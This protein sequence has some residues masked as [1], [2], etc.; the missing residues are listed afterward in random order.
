M[1]DVGNTAD[2]EH[3]IESIEI[4][5]S[6]GQTRVIPVSKDKLTQQKVQ[7][8][9]TFRDKSKPFTFEAKSAREAEKVRRA[10][11]TFSP[12]LPSVILIDNN[13]IKIGNGEVVDCTKYLYRDLEKRVSFTHYPYPCRN[14][15]KY[16]KSTY[17]WIAASPDLIA[18]G[19]G[20]E[21]HGIE[22]DTQK[23]AVDLDEFSIRMEWV[24]R[25]IRNESD[26]KILW[27]QS[28]ITDDW[29]NG[30]KD[31]L[32]TTANAKAYAERT[33]NIC[34]AND[35]SYC[36]FSSIQ[37]TQNGSF[38]TSQMMRHISDQVGSV[39]GLEIK[40]PEVEIRTEKLSSNAIVDQVKGYIVRQIKSINK[41]V[42][43]R[44]RQRAKKRIA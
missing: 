29:Y 32:F 35:V 25:K 12:D 1:Y 6:D 44:I 38:A 39:L 27:V 16:C 11:A 19:C 24:I 26:T 17:D 8:F 31:L 36:D 30:S 43:K 33:R 15:R 42:K 4:T 9:L 20:L 41:S 28:P 23:P 2:H 21:D 13:G 3:R 7:Q 40:I 14:V 34:I 10:L 18:L 37:L 22:M 5:L